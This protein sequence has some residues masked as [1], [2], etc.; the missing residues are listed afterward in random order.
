MTG[1]SIVS[2]SASRQ[3][4]FA[5]I[6]ALE[7]D[8]RA[9]IS[10]LLLPDAEDSLFTLDE[11]QKVRKRQSRDRETA[12]SGNLLDYIDFADGFLVLLRNGS[13]LP[14]DL[15]NEL[16]ANQS[17]LN[18]LVPVRNRVAH[19]RPME[20][21]DLTLTLDVTNG[22]ATGRN[23]TYW[24]RLTKALSQLKVD[25]SYVLGLTIDLRSDPDNTPV[26]NLPVPDFDETGFF[27]RR[28]TINRIKKIIKGPYPVV[29]ILGDGGIGKS[30]I[31]LKV[32]YELLDDPKQSFDS[33]VWVTAKS[34]MLTVNE[35]QRINGAIE[36]SLGLFAH[37]AEQL[38][39]PGTT[40]PMKEVLE[41]LEHFHILLII[42]NLETVLDQNLKDFLLDLPL[43]SKVMLTSR[44]GAGIENP[45]RL[46]P[47]EAGES[48]RLLYALARVRDVDA[49]KGLPPETMSKI[50]SN[51]GGRPAFIKWFVAGVQAG[52]RPEELLTENDLFL[53]FCMSNVHEF[54]GHRAKSVLNCMQVLPGVR[55]HGELAFLTDMTADATQA[56][57]L[58]L[59]T[60]N[61][62]H[63]KSQTLS[64]QG[65]SFDTG[66]ELTE[67][68]RDYL[69]K[70]HP[71][72]STA[73][74]AIYNK[75][76]TL[77][78]EGTRLQAANAAS[79][80]DPTTISVR[81]LSDFGAA[82]LLKEAIVHVDKQD[83]DDAIKSC[84]EA[85]TL[86]PAFPEAWRVEGYI[87]SLTSDFAS[88]RRAYERACDLSPDSPTL[89]Y[90]FGSFLLDENINLI[91]GLELLQRAARKAPDQPEVLAQIAWAHFRVKD[92]TASIETARHALSVNP[93]HHHSSIFAITAL[94][95]TVHYMRML[96]D[97][98]AVEKAV[99]LLEETV[100]LTD[101]LP[102]GLLQG[103]A[104]DRALQLRNLAVDLTMLATDSFHADKCYI[105][106]RKLEE[107]VHMEGESELERIVGQVK[108]IVAAKFFG[109]VR[110]ERTD[111]FFHLRDLQSQTDWDHIQIGGLVAFVPVPVGPRGARAERVAWID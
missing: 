93:G 57:L 89:N 13:K 42:D 98:E 28:A 87:H 68:G 35:I 19:S 41:Y 75:S 105:F 1:G 2:F 24:P 83:Y 71:V 4:C 95:A 81:D 77:L 29:S 110:A 66:Y 16:R 84:T 76:K 12:A 33:I 103:E 25:P 43:G 21:E 39:G 88:G 97:Q 108:N 78:A 85:Q 58:E 99:E 74:L 50:V 59:L 101:S 72:S 109:F 44:I 49:L 106:K 100:S 107:R 37:A 53:D 36:D 31:A 32:A 3:T 14:D 7:E 67:F 104:L 65:Y 52:R 51:M 34:T 54:L 10:S 82:K 38:A 27:G 64:P 111:Y 9:A 6:S 70:R 17:N 48:E 22:L 45:V 63:M 18:K 60:T 20:I 23:R 96:L 30:S 5:L 11:I 102:V 55:S 91:E 92:Y 94:R 47:L 69:N 73:R 26:H 61:F 8:L 15:H 80:Y 62:I 40:D 86:A 79:P 90:F 46:D 56:A